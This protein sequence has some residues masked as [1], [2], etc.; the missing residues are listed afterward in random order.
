[1]NSKDLTCLIRAVT[2]QNPCADNGAFLLDS[3]GDMSGLN[4]QP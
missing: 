3:L 1:M 4:A 2:N